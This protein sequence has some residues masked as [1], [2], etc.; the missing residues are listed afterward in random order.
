MILQFAY[1]LC[2]YDCHDDRWLLRCCIFHI[3]TCLWSRVTSVSVGTRLRAGRSRSRRWNFGRTRNCNCLPSLE[4][5]PRN[6]PASF[7]KSTEDSFRAGPGS[8]SKAVDKPVWH[9]PLL[10]VQRINSWWCPKHVEF[11]A[12]INLW[13]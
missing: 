10:S 5:S 8:C 6:N 12:G 2:V 13:N 9:I 4:I 11:Y 3:L 1:I 7:T